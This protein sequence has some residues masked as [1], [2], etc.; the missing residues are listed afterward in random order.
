MFKEPDAGLILSEYEVKDPNVTNL[1]RGGKIFRLPTNADLEL[2]DDR[3]VFR[4]R[5][6]P[7]WGFCQTHLVLYRLTPNGNTTCPS[8]DPTKQAQQEATR[9]IRACPRGHVD[10]VNWVGI[11]H[12]GGLK[13]DSELYDWVETGPS[14]WDI[15]IQCQNLGAKQAL[16]F[17]IF[18]IRHGNA[19][20]VLLKTMLLSL[21]KKRLQLFL[22]MQAI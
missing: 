5:R 7:E 13:C 17:R 16:L 12:S 20:D 6:F 18:I 1:L 14:M 4:T 2:P 3:V 11:V 15:R 8:R 22:E 9:F 10:D 19:P 21:A